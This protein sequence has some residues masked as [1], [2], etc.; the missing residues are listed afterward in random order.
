MKKFCKHSFFFLLP[1]LICSFCYSF[2]LFKSGEY[3]KIV[4]GSEVYSSIR[5]SKKKVYVKK[6]II[7]DSTAF[8]FFNNQDG[9]DIFSL[10]CNQ[11]ISLCGHYLLL[12][13]FLLAGNR[14]SEVY[15]VYMPFSFCNNLDEIYTYGYFLKPFFK[16]E[17]VPLMTEQVLEQ[18]GKIPY[19]EICQ[20]PL[21]LTSSWVPSYKPRE[22]E[23]TFLS[24]ISCEYL[25]KMEELSTKYNFNLYIVP[26]I[27]SEIQKERIN[28]IDKA[29]FN[30][31]KY[32]DKL[33]IYLNNILYVDNSHFRDGVHLKRPS[34]FYSLMKEKMEKIKKEYNKV[35][36]K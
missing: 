29:E 22:R 33:N 18:I 17:Y 27:L 30:K 36:I 20:F 12:N 8:Q 35:G 2:Y 6:L 3:E 13:N 31:E 1:L 28:K 25:R 32:A 24:S 9:N 23:N 15:L 34:F 14:P 10:A 26:S 16:D 11:A 5:N 19:H 4:T 21:V 7:G